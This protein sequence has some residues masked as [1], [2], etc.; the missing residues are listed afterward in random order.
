MPS[1]L[2]PGEPAPADGSLPS[3]A[4]AGVGRRPF[5]FYVHV[6]FCAVRCGYCDF[7]TYTA[8]ELGGVPG[9][10]RATT[11]RT[12]RSPR[13]G[14]PA[15]CSA[16]WTS[17][18]RRSSSAAEPRRCCRPRT[19]PDLAAIDDEFGLAPG[20]EVTTESN[21]DSVTRGGPRPARGTGGS[22]GSPSGCSP[23]AARA[24]GAR[25]H[26]RPAPGPEGRRL[27]AGGRVRAGQPGPDLRHAGGVAG[28]LAQRRST[29]ALACEPD[30]VSAYALIVEEG[31]AL[32]RQVR[33]G[34][35]R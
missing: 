21:P 9:P 27:G 34:R 32:A 23:R 5:G 15:R 30:H 4:L 1:D 17:R 11:T 25:P 19:W 26:P 16:P 18:W 2:P 7:N 28:G 14:S 35:C 20:A 22:P 31:T 24:A 29:A 8:T 3:T 6:P 12:R 33:R 10:S 13:S